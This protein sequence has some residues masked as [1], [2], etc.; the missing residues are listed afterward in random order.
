MTMNIAG[1]YA[2]VLGNSSLKSYEHQ[3]LKE[4]GKKIG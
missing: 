3:A 2:I 1:Y 4:E